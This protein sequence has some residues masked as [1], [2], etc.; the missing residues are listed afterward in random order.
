MKNTIYAT[1]SEA[2]NG[3]RRGGYEEDFNLIQNYIE[4]R[5]FKILHDEFHIDKF[6][7]FEGFTDPGDE[8]ILYAISSAKYGIK[9]ILV[10]GYGI[11]AD[12]LSSQMLE[13]LK[14]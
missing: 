12:S 10:N 2:I 3:L 14:V 5:N 4:C 8:S 1:S 13:K 6:Y 11:S 7:R 9:G